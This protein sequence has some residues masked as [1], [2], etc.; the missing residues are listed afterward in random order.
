MNALALKTKPASFK[1]VYVIS[2][3]DGFLADF[4]FR[5]LKNFLTPNFADLNVSVVDYAG[6]EILD[7]KATLAALPLVDDFRIIKLENYKPKKSGEDEFLKTIKNHANSKDFSTVIVVFCPEGNLKIDDAENIDCNHLNEFE[8]TQFILNQADLIG[9]KITKGAIEKLKL[10][11]LGDLSRINNELTKLA[12]LRRGQEINEEDV[13]DNVYKDK[14]YQVFEIA[15]LIARGE[16]EKCVDCFCA[17]LGDRFI[18]TEADGYT[19]S[20]FR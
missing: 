18:H 4:A 20:H 10:F 11:T 5:Q 9:A 2:G 19:K 1:S 12:F 7:F 17:V 16:K 13:E 15:N 14:E 3:D 8:L 6:A